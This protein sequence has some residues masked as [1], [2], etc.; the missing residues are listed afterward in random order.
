MML[1]DY[2]SQFWLHFWFFLWSYTSAKWGKADN[3]CI[4]DDKLS[5]E[6]E[7][8]AKSV[9]MCHDRHDWD[10]W[11]WVTWMTCGVSASLGV[12]SVPVMLMSRHLQALQVRHSSC[13][14]GMTLWLTSSI[15]LASLNF[16]LRQ[17]PLLC[18][19]ILHVNVLHPKS[20]LADFASSVTL[21]SLR[22]RTKDNAFGKIF[23]GKEK[24]DLLH[25][26]DERHTNDLSFSYNF[27]WRSFW[28]WNC[29]SQERIW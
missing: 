10:H 20:S 21:S 4:R 17:H 9:L 7:K 16:L 1:Y 23:T 13:F 29:K 6:E 8:E 26:E 25:A 22:K 2:G 14:Q 28:R 18:K 24:W 15:S 11:S 19:R 3:K 12:M 5:I 27:H